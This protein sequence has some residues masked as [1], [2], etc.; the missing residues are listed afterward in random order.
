MSN[1]ENTDSD[2]SSTDKNISKL[3]EMAIRG[4]EYREELELDYYQD[5]LTIVCR[6]LTDPEFLPIAAFL[7]EKLDLDPEDAAEKIEEEREDDEEEG[8][9]MEN[10]DEDFVEI[11]AEAAIMGIDTTQG[12]AKGEDE[13]GLREILGMT[14]DENANIGLQGGSTLL[15]AEKVLNLSSDSEGA[16]SFRRDGGGE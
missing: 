14:D 10:F 6:P 16:K 5:T 3:R 1:T 4:K 13:E 11:M 7:E 15:I 9:S 8:L 12:D 2:S